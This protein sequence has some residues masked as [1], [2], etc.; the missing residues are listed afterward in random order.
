[1][2]RGWRIISNNVQTSGPMMMMVPVLIWNN[3][4]LATYLYLLFYGFNSKFLGT[5]FA[6]IVYVGK[7]KLI[8][9]QAWTG[10]EGSR[11]LRLPYFQ[12]NR[13][14]MVIRLSPLLTGRLYHQETFLI[15][16]SVRGWVDPRDHSAAGRIISMKNFNDTIGNQSRDLPACSIVPQP[17]APPAACPAN[18]YRCRKYLCW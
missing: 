18:V 12:D 4:S 6:G 8:P 5:R 16:I 10:P 7:G 3:S 13:H 15:L 1:M 2:T 17:T 11:R 9:L 14:M